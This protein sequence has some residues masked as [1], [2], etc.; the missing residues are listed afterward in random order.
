MSG[1]RLDGK[2]AIVTGGAAGS[3]GAGMGRAVSELFGREGASVVPVDVAPE[4]EVTAARVRQ[5]G[6]EATA[7][8]ADVEQRGDVERVVRTAL[9]RYGKVDVLVNVVGGSIGEG[10]Y[11]AVTDDLFETI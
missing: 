4:V 8:R 9:E 2:V 3:S 1:A 7:V 11:L 10:G 6:G 5:A